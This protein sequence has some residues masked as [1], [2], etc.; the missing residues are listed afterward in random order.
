MAFSLSSR[1]AP[2]RADALFF[3][4]LLSITS[5]IP[6]VS[7]F[8]LNIGLPPL[9]AAADTLADCIIKIRDNGT[10][11][12]LDPGVHTLGNETIDF[13]QLPYNDLYLKGAADRTTV[14]DGSEDITSL[15]TWE[16]C[17]T[18]TSGN[19]KQ[20]CEQTLQNEPN[21]NSNTKIYSALLPKYK[22]VYQLWAQTETGL[23][24]KISRK[25]WYPHGG[26]TRFR[27]KT[28]R[29]TTTTGCWKST[30]I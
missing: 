23:R 22:P 7:V 17:S 12:D 11:C 5:S 3:A 1:F 18:L 4:L 14:I 26:R 27:T 29:R 24:E 25:C 30:Q 13:L 16:E 20:I 8:F 28:S 15:L 2:R 21:V 6:E 10:A 19:Y 9:F